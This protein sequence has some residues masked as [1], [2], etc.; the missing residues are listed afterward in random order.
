MGMQ[1][2]QRLRMT[3]SFQIFRSSAE[4]GAL[5]SQGFCNQSGAVMQR[6]DPYRKIHT[7]LYQINQPIC[8][9]DIQLECRMALGN[10]QKSG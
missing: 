2:V 8:Q 3:M 10:F 5:N 7:L 9:I 6:A 4:N 1:L